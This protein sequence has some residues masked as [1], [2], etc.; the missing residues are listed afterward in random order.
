M[1]R[2][3]KWGP[4]AAAAARS[5]R[6]RR[7]CLNGD[8]E[9]WRLAFDELQMTDGGD[10]FRTPAPYARGI[11]F[12]RVSAAAVATAEVPATAPSEERAGVRALLADDL[13][14]TVE[15]H[16]ASV[17]FIHDHFFPPDFPVAPL[18]FGDGGGGE[19]FLFTIG[20]RPSVAFTRTWP[21]PFL[22]TQ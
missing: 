5:A 18:S 11:I 15:D 17:A 6:D 9:R 3:R 19:G 1:G 13:P 7:A 10:G 12:S 2:S 21:V 20:C 4:S 16:P 22:L 8:N 14:A